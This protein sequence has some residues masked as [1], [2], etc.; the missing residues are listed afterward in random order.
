[1]SVNTQTV[2]CEI[3]TM[4]YK[5]HKKHIKVSA[6]LNGG[7]GRVVL[8]AECNSLESYELLRNYYRSES[9]IQFSHR[10]GVICRARPYGYTCACVIQ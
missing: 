1:M 10:D 8:Y 4:A 9:F 2:E 5:P 3:A 6:Y 7:K